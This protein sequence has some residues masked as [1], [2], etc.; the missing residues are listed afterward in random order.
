MSENETVDGR[1]PSFLEKISPL[2]FA[3][4][5]GGLSLVVMIVTTC[6]AMS[7]DGPLP[8]PRKAPPPPE[9]S[10]VLSDRFKKGFYQAQLDDD[11]KLL[12]I[13]RVT[14]DTL[15][16]GNPYTLEFSG[17]TKLKPG[18]KL[19]TES[20]FLRAKIRRLMVGEEGHGIRAPHLLLSIT[21]RTDKFLAYRVETTVSGGNNKAHLAHNAIAL[22]PKATVVRSESLMRESSSLV[23]KKVEVIELTRLGY[24][25]VSRLDPERLQFSPRTATGHQYRG[26]LRPCKLLPWRVIRDGMREGVTRWFDV[27]DFYARHSCSEYTFFKGYRWSAQGVKSLPIKP[28]FAKD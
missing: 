17:S 1:V 11:C 6:S 13:R 24:H 4:A 27:V 5:M 18:G 7:V 9:T 15:R 26:A 28:P 12:K 21:N 3:L 23:V 2:S 20:L 10:A 16:G 14:M 19:E 22:K 25:Y 8:P